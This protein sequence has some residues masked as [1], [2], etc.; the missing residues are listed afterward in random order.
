M[1]G[2]QTIALGG[3]ARA[4]PAETA[5]SCWSCS[6]GGLRPSLADVNLDG[7]GDLLVRFRT[8]EARIAVGDMDACVTGRA[9]SGIPFE[10]WDLI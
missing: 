6:G 2:T 1:Q 3:G 5:E 8:P 7:F 4:L 9:R 10:G